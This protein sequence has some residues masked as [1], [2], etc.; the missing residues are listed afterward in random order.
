M[1]QPMRNKKSL[2]K[3]EKGKQIMKMWNNKRDGQKVQM[4]NYVIPLVFS[5]IAAFS[6]EKDLLRNTSIV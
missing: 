1:W 3:T 4:T 2:S 6:N 5:R